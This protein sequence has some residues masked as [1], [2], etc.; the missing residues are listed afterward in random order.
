MSQKQMNNTDKI[1]Q[2]IVNGCRRGVCDHNGGYIPI[3]KMGQNG[4]GSHYIAMQRTKSEIENYRR[5]YER[6]FGHS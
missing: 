2:A 5:N 4:Q 3:E 1:K 6:I